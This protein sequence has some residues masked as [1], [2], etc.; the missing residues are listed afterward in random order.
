MISPSCD[1]YRLHT[2]LHNVTT[3]I[4]DKWYDA[5]I[6]YTYVASYS[7]RIPAPTSIFNYKVYSYNIPEGPYVAP[8]QRSQLAIAT[9]LFR[10][11]Q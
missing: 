11:Q 9:K 10:S 4:N 1:Q 7:K 8:V 3:K 6:P 2:W 5:N